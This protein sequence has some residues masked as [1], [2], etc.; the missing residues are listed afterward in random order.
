MVSMCR[1]WKSTKRTSLIFT[2]QW[3]LEKLF[4]RHTCHDLCLVLQGPVY[5]DVCIC[6]CISVL[7]Y[8]NDKNITVLSHKRA[9]FQ[10]DH[11]VGTYIY[12]SHSVRGHQRCP[13]VISHSHIAQSHLVHTHSRHWKVG[14]LL[15]KQN[16][17]RQLRD[18][19]IID[20]VKVW[21]H[22]SA[23]KILAST[24]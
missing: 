19:C 23:T 7:L 13:H 2:A 10:N 22:V 4:L 21:P 3:L 5:V 9:L 20:R 14:Y 17:Y 18:P 15:L 11:N 1:Q 16:S 8:K 6:V 24:S 12:Q